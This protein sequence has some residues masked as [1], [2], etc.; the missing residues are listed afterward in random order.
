MESDIHLSP[1]NWGSLLGKRQDEVQIYIRS[2][3]WPS[4]NASSLYLKQCSNSN[5]CLAKPL[6]ET[7][8]QSEEYSKK[9]ILPLTSDS[10]RSATE[11]AYLSHPQFFSRIQWLKQKMY[12]KGYIYIALTLHN[13]FWTSRVNVIVLSLRM[14][15]QVGCCRAWFHRKAVN[16]TS[17]PA[18]IKYIAST[19]THSYT[20]YTQDQK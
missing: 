14:M 15:V 18:P 4:I 11:M 16:S 5:D 13:I 6:V 20:N 7:F 19:L 2:F 1:E 10:T 8:Q 12:N 9:L 17:A 3:C